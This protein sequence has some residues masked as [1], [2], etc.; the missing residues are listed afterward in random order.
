[1]AK[2]PPI[3]PT[4]DRLI[5]KPPE[6]AYLLHLSLSALYKR[7]ADGVIPHHYEGHRLIFLRH[8]LDAYL[9]ALPG[10]S[11]EAAQ[12]QRQRLKNLR[13]NGV[14][15]GGDMQETSGI[16]GTKKNAVETH[17]STDET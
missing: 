5:L 11:V 6:A 12:A 3:P 9:A 15:R 4:T 7:V 14:S 8:E 16:K 13:E 1:M 17:V 10:I 2:L